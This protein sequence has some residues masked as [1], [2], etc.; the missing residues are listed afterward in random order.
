MQVVPIHNHS[1]YSVFDGLATVDEIAAR[2]KE[3]GSEH[4]GLTDHGVVAGHLAFNKACQRAGLH[5]L[6]GMEAYQ[7]RTERHVVWRDGLVRNGRPKDDAFHLVL[8]A[9]DDQGL[10]NL[11]KMSSLAH[12]TGFA[13][14]PRVDWDLL[15]EYS[16]GIIA[17]SACLGGMV[18]WDINHDRTK[19]LEHYLKIFGDRFYVELHT[20]ATDYQKQM[21]LELVRLAKKFG[22]PMVYATD[23][24]YSCKDEWNDHEHYIAIAQ[25]KEVDDPDRHSHP[26]SL[27]IADEDGIRAA[28]DYLPTSVVD[29]AISNSLV[30]AES[31]TA[32]I[33]TPR[34]HVPKFDVPEDKSNKQFLIQLVQEG[35]RRLNLFDKEEYVE[36]AQKELEVIF[37]FP[38]LIDYFLIQWDITQYAREQGYLVGPGRGSVGGSLVAYLLSITDIDPLRYGLIF[39]RFYNAGRAQG[40]L[41]DID[42]D[43]PTSCRDDIKRYVAEKYGATNV[44]AIGTTMRLHGKSAI[45][46]VNWVYHLPNSDITVIKNLIDSQVKAGLQ[47]KWEKILELDEMQPYIES[48]PEFFRHVTKFYGRVYA[49]GVHASGYIISDVDLYENFP[50][51]WNAKK[52]EL[53]TQFDMHEA[54]EMGFMK[55]DFLGLRNLDTLMELKRLVKLH[56][57]IDWEVDKLHHISDNEMREKKFWEFFERGRTVGIFQVEDGKGAQKMAQAIRPRTLE[58]LALLVALNR[59]GPD[60]ET[61]IARKNGAPWD[62]IDPI[63]EDVLDETFGVF[64]FQEQIIRTMTKIGFTEGEADDIRRIMGKKKTDDMKAAYPK[65][66]EKALDH[67]SED[68]AQEIWDAVSRFAE[69][70]FNKSHAVGYAAIGVWTGI[71]KED[72]PDLSMLACIRTDPNP[73]ARPLYIAES[74]LMGVEV[75]PPDINKSKFETDLIDGTIYYGLKDVKGVSRGAQWI[76][77]NRPFDS[78]DDLI[79][80]LEAA[81]KDFLARKKAGETE[82]AERS[83]KQLLGINKVNAL[84]DAGAFDALEPRD[85]TMRERRAFELAL[86]GCVITN[87]APKV[88]D[89]W[90]SKLE[91]VDDFDDIDEEG[92]YAVLGYIS[93]IEEKNTARGDKMMWLTLEN[94]PD[95][96]RVAAFSNVIARYSHVLHEYMPVLVELKKTPRGLNLVRARELK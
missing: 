64:I 30:I 96:L 52:E 44:G 79:E 23:A 80:K 73:D 20:Y 39:E 61:Y 82:H 9:Q 4:V 86:L 51:K 26:Q 1:E 31:C 77:D 72:F 13:S 10:K 71:G 42:T 34:P 27:W 28:L 8:L 33:P 35:A 57:G 55:N 53:S 87:S 54:E 16:K 49:V 56:H 18:V 41:P 84:R 47:P 69:Y 65:Y 66:M 11:W 17:T 43:F 2:I 95:T 19:A 12:A 58:E 76:V 7:A 94:G 15:A 36:R 38:V 81:N 25:H 50:V 91:D 21:N 46:R 40:G 48:Y 74:R 45:D 85:I 24:H 75:L 60:S 3:I 70:G 32:E 89:K 90:R 22:I 29:E 6:F 59:P 14:R 88:V 62:F 93:K 92:E 5:P 63:L 37:S 68:S 78:Y 67:M 83:P